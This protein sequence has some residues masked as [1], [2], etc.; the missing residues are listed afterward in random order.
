MPSITRTD[1]TLAQL[2]KSASSKRVST[3]RPLHTAAPA[4]PATRPRRATS[5]SAGPAAT[6]PEAEVRVEG[7]S[8][9][10][11][12]DLGFTDAE[13]RLA[14][15][16]LARIV[17]HEVR[18]RMAREGWT[19]ARAAKLLGI[20]APDMSNLMRGK[21]ARFGQERLETFLTC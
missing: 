9:N 13:D 1:V 14:K 4:R 6:A 20:T 5:K 17:R 10:V 18:D 8:G 11:F 19:Q 21:L 12:A 3:G 7:S 2:T 16:Q 15:A